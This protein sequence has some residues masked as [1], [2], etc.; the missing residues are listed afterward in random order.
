MN[1]EPSSQD[2]LG[3]A[4]SATRA[5]QRANSMPRWVPPTVALLGGAS[6]LVVG[7]ADPGSDEFWSVMAAGCGIAC[8][9]VA[10]MS[11][12]WHAQRKRGVVPRRLLDVPVRR[13]QRISLLVLIV[14]VPALVQ[15]F[16]HG[17]AHA[18]FALALTAWV[19]WGLEFERR[20]TCPS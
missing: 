7:R 2:M 11:W 4:S 20:T 3:I 10:L 8:L 9:F 17:W 5:A 15:N 13:W 12:V 14:L 19:W 16:L 1:D 18:V 6:V